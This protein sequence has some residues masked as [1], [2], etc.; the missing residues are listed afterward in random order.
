MIANDT[1]GHASITPNHARIL[2]VPA[3]S[4]CRVD[5]SI[6]HHEIPAATT[7]RATRPV[8]IRP[9]MLLRNSIPV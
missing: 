6:C 8:T 7:P 5:S 3:T 9:E 2:P 4:V 1:H